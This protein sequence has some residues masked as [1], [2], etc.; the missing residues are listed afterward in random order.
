MLDTLV[1]AGGIWLES[2]PLRWVSYLALIMVIYVFL[3]RL[4]TSWEAH[5]HTK[6]LLIQWL[7]AK[8]AGNIFS[9]KNEV[10]PAQ[11]QKMAEQ[12]PLFLQA[13]SNSLQAG[14]TLPMALEFIAEEIEDPLQTEAKRINQDLK[15]Q[16]PLS[17]CLENLAKK[18][19]NHEV[20]F[21]VESTLIQLKTGGNLI[22]LFDKTAFL[23][24][25]KLKLKRDIKSFT[26]QGKLSGILI[27]TLWPISLAAFAWLSPAHTQ[28][29]F[30]TTTGQ[31]MLVVSL[32]FEAIGFFFIW[33]IISVKL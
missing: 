15:L 8:T 20:D 2:W 4:W 9:K 6:N 25:E 12:M 24:E 3:C 18:V 21:F 31:I 22:K 30:G 17:D 5:Q 13:L 28:I 29:L 11:R 10:W 23:I 32:V 27:A 16:I 7:P 1:L 14:Y 33:K 19:Q 26:S